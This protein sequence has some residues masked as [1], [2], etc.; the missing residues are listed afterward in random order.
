[1]M[2]VSAEEMYPEQVKDYMFMLSIFPSGFDG[3]AAQAILKKV[4]LSPPPP[5]AKLTTHYLSLL[6]LM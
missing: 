5:K 1:M 3:P 2:G 6:L 4:I